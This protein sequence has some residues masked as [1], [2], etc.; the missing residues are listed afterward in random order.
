MREG[1]RQWVG[2]GG[3]WRG[4]QQL[5]TSCL[6]LEANFGAERGLEGERKRFRTLVGLGGGWGVVGRF[7]YRIQT[8]AGGGNRKSH[9]TERLGVCVNAW[10]YP[11]T[12]PMEMLFPDTQLLPPP[13]ESTNF[14]INSQQL[15]K[16]QHFLASDVGNWGKKSSALA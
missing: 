10:V 3:S 5:L 2:G 11:T 8:A 16:K 15:Y 14:P 6:S 12:T 7:V 1:W 4:S 13:L 9:L